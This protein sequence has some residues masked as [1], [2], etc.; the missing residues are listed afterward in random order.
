MI[1]PDQS[2]RADP[3]AV[4]RLVESRGTRFNAQ[5]VV[6]G[7]PELLLSP[8]VALGRL[9]RDVTEQE[10]DLIQFDAGKMAETGAGAPQVMRGSLS[11]PARAAAARTTSQSTLG[12][13]PCPQ[14]RPALLIARKTGPRA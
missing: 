6:D 8:E 2:R 9:D 7:V 5:A 11:M 10:L 13:M 4:L 3:G 1:S 12:D 14:T